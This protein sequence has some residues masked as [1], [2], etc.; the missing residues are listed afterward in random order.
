M[1]AGLHRVTEAGKNRKDHRCASSNV[2]RKDVKTAGNKVWYTTSLNSAA[3]DTLFGKAASVTSAIL[4]TLVVTQDKEMT[5]GYIS[6]CSTHR[7]RPSICLFKQ[8]KAFS[9]NST[10]L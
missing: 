1:T 2:Y 8:C 3:G 9:A 10:Q 7:R 6:H 4:A 5:T